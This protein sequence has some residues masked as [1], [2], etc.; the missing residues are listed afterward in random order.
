MA[1]EAGA[2]MGGP[3]GR[4]R[5]CEK[6]SK[7]GGGGEGGS[8]DARFDVLAGIGRRRRAF[9]SLFCPTFIQNCAT[10][11]V[12]SPRG[13]VLQRLN[14]LG[15]ERTERCKVSAFGEPWSAGRC[16]G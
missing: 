4:I 1:G 3:F 10:P 16:F 15:W 14:L 5:R 11:G 7:G 8:R 2:V 12:K 13:I 9:A 6:D